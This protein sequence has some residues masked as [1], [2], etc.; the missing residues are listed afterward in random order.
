MKLSGLFVT[1]LVGFYTIYD[2]WELFGDLKISIVLGLFL[3][4]FC[5]NLPTIT[6]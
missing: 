5:S 4:L 6:H 1:A 2:L 3:L